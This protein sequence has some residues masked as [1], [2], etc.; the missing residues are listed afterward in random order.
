V[1]G[2]ILAWLAGVAVAA[3]WANL[4][5]LAGAVV[6]GALWTALAIWTGGLAAPIASHLLWTACMLAWPPS[7]ARAKVAG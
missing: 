3:A 7:S 2:A 6:G 1:P 5:F 4:P